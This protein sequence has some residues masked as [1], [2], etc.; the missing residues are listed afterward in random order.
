MQISVLTSAELRGTIAILKNADKEI[1]KEIKRAVRSISTPEWQGVV[2]GNRA[3]SLQNRVLVQTAKVNVSNTNVT[4]TSG[5][6]NKRMRGGAT[7]A[8]LVRAAEFGTLSRDARKTYTTRS[9]KGN[10]YTVTRRTLRQIPSRSTRGYAVYPAAAEFIPR[11]ASLYAQTTVRTLHEII[12][13]K[14]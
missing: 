2:S 14:R 11:V 13:R 1:S 7:P 12:E 8:L 4:L 3:N 5:A 9:R 10:S 6:S